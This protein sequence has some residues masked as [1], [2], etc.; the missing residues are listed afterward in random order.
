MNTTHTVVIGA[1]QAGLAISRCLHDRGIEHAVLE[2]GRVGQSWTNRWDSL[3]LLSPNWM[4]RLPGWRYS[5]PDPNGFMTHNEV[6][7]FLDGYARSFQAPVEED[8]TV[9]A[10]F[11]A[12][13][14]WTVE[15]NRGVWHA[16][17]VVVATGHSQETRV[18]AMASALP[19]DIRQVSSSQYRNPDQVPEGVVLVVGASASGVQ[20]ADELARAGREVILAAGQ[21]TRLP[22]RYRGR[23]IMCWLDRIGVLQRPLSDMPNPQQAKREPS[24]QLTGTDSGRNVD[25]GTLRQE[26]VR[27]VGRLVGLEQ[28]NLM[29][30]TDLPA[31]ADDA[32]RRMAHLL[33]KIDQHIAAHGLDS[34][35]PAPEPWRLTPLTPLPSSLSLARAGIR[36]VVWATGYRRTYPWLEADVFDERGEIRNHRGRTSAPGLFIL[37]QQF[38]IRRNSSFIDGVGQDAREIADAIAQRA[39]RNKK[40]AA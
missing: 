6:R 11:P 2:R 30:G 20:L 12:S 16:R 32:D 8:T 7:A 1:G 36:S 22:R 4:T 27:I 24:L 13:T 39:A 14:W 28:G 38:M 34:T 18:P 3:R 17:N 19:R 37:G 33:A 29:L 26:G 21:H 15:T 5:G 40:E 23:D 35:L 9:H 10:V 31:H 25:L